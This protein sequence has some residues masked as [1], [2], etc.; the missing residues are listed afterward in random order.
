M[1]LQQALGIKKYSWS[2]QA[3]TWSMVVIICQMAS[4]SPDARGKINVRE[5][6]SSLSAQVW[7]TSVICMW[8]VL[9]WGTYL[10][11][12]RKRRDRMKILTWALHS[13]MLVVITDNLTS[14]VG[15]FA[16]WQVVIAAGVMMPLLLLQVWL[17]VRVPS[18]CDIVI[19]VPV[20]MCFQM[21]FNMLSGIFIWRDQERMVEGQFPMYLST[22]LLCSITIFIL[23]QSDSESEEIRA[24]QEMLYSEKTPGGTTSIS[25]RRVTT[26]FTQVGP[27]MSLADAQSCAVKACLSVSHFENHTVDQE[28]AQARTLRRNSLSEPSLVS[29]ARGSIA[30]QSLRFDSGAMT[31]IPT[32]DSLDSDFVSSRQTSH[33]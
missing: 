25:V 4:V 19:Y 20:F 23:S 26:M 5:V 9:A 22:F 15:L 2:M 29:C 27:L 10:S 16:S 33:G 32:C 17:F 7:C 8:V 18:H 6:L 1:V 3:C 14:F 12:N 31:P 30:G 24:L 13:S 11:S 21:F 28:V